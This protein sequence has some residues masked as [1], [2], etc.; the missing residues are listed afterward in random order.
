[1]PKEGDLDMA[2]LDIRPQDF[3]ELMKMDGPGLLADLAD[4]DS[5]LAKFGDRVPPRLVAQLKAQ[6][7]RLA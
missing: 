4:A 7:E 5:F 6:K 3:A 2:G 1:M